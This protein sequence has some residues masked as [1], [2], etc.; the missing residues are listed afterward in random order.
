MKL[1]DAQQRQVEAFEE[2]KEDGSQ[3]QIG[4][5]KPGN[6]KGVLVTLCMATEPYEGSDSGFQHQVSA[7][8][9]I[10]R[11]DTETNKQTNQ[12]LCK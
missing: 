12:N 5:R 4:Q 1:K 3:Q 10:L 2:K 11:R 8:E 9:T 6:L 7:L